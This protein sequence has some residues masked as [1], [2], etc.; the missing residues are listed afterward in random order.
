MPDR[1]QVPVT[2]ALPSC[3]QLHGPPEPP[4]VPVQEA[5]AA[6]GAGERLRVQRRTQLQLPIGL[7][8]RLLPMARWPDRQTD[9]QADRQTETRPRVSPL[10][11]SA[12][13]RRCATIL[14]L[15]AEAELE[16]RR[17]AS[18]HPPGQ[19]GR[20]CLTPPSGRR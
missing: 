4:C 20:N 9:R 1:A 16:T 11:R 17:L 18:T 10:V 5:L 6:A 19:A 2:F 12:A 15:R 3:G 13:V 14:R 8:P 7:L